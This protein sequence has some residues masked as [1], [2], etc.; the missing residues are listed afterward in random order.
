M[1]TELTELQ[2]KLFDYNLAMDKVNTQTNI[3]DIEE[4]YLE[5]RAANEIETRH[6]EEQ[7]TERSKKQRQ[8]HELESEIEKERKHTESVIDAMD[9]GLKMKYL[10]LQDQHKALLNQM[11]S[12]QQQ[13]D[14]LGYQTSVLRDKMSG[15]SIKLEAVQLSETLAELEEQYK[16]LLE[17]EENKLTPEQE[18]EKLLLQLKNDNYE[19]TNAETNMQMIEAQ[20]KEAEGTLEQ[21]NQDLEES[22]SEK[23]QKYIELKKR[24]DIIETFL[25]SYDENKR[26]ETDKIRQLESDIV[27]ALTNQSL[28]IAT[29]PPT[30]SDLHLLRNSSNQ[31]VVSNSEKTVETLQTELRQL[32]LNLAKVST[33]CSNGGVVF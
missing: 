24:E 33:D 12:A 32:N 11:D 31:S 29:L 2:G 27:A 18:R 17:E 30:Q 21:L 7:F 28:H 3:V 5:L 8:L 10:E 13:V 16:T 22:Q 6:L 25:A 23:H 20:I 26:L 15:S 4:E 14:T 9:P 1:A 19:I